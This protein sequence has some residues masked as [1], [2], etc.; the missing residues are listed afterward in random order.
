MKITCQKNIFLKAINIVSKAVSAKTTLPILECILIDAT[1]DVVTLT[2]NDM[3]LGIET[4]MEAD[5]KESGM[6]AV[7]AKMLGEIIRKVPDDAVTL[8]T[9]ANDQVMITSGKYHAQIEGQSG[10]EFSFLPQVTREDFISLSEFSLREA[11]RQT[12]F[13]ISDNDTK[14]M[15]T[16]E[17]MEVS[18]DLLK[19]VSLDGH[20]ISI[21]KIVLKENYEP[22]KVIVP[23]KTLQEISKII[24]GDPDETIRIYFAKNHAL[25]EFE[26]TVVVT[27]LI[28]GEYY[29]IDQMLSSDYETK[30]TVNKKA[31]LEGID[32]A[33]SF[34]RDSD[35]KPIVLTI[36]DDRIELR[37]RSQI[38]GMNDELDVE[39]TGRDLVIGFNPKFLLDALRVIDDEQVDLYFMNPKSPCFMKD[40][41][42]SYIYL[43]LPVNI[44]EQA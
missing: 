28:E 34:I 43:I 4:R 40:E 39:K 33:T 19:V 24:G 10:E 15:M 5:I 3:E 23:G 38:G 25:F 32:R 30:V 26:D 29:K 12:I 6:Y 1:K 9:M 22:K 14:V 17:L 16:G 31:L 7:N 35:K 21:R 2:A 11:I 36:K 44:G 41:K 20:R 8:E 42:E 13:S 27:R 18:G 37:L